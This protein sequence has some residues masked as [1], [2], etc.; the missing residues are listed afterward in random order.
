[1]NKKWL[2]WVLCILVF[3]LPSFNTSAQQRPPIEVFLRHNKDANHVLVYFTDSQTGLSAIGTV[4]NYPDTGR[5]L[6]DFSLSPQG[7]LFRDPINGAPRLMTTNGDIFGFTFIPQNTIPP[8]SYD[9]VVSENGRTL[10]WAEFLFQDGVWQSSIY[11]ADLDG[12]NIRPI[13]NPPNPIASA[14]A[15]LIAVSNNGERL[16]LDIAHPIEPRSANDDFVEY[17]TLR[18]YLASRQQYLPIAEDVNCPCPVHVVEDGHT[19]LQLE[20]PIIGNGYDLRIWNLDVNTYQV[21]PAADTIYQQGGSLHLSPN[22]T[23]AAFSITR[24]ES[25]SNAIAS[26]IV[27]ADILQTSQRII[28]APSDR[29]FN[30]VRF[31]N[32]DRDLILADLANGETFK[33]NLETETYEQIADK[34]WLGTLPQ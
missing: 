24:L 31:Y 15:K 33:V 6:E 34:I 32:N 3:I 4:N 2:I 12:G 10:A 22:R 1:M 27:V 14:R 30:I 13:I 26:G 19:L 7:V 5:I 29:L 20:R 23:L 18:V 28:S 11:I 8:V 25:Q 16:F 17:T 9:W 21:I